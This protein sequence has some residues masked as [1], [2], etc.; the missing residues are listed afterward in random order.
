MCVYIYVCVL[1]IVC[2]LHVCVFVGIELTSM[3]WNGKP[4]PSCS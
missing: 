2:F 3:D 1:C 4:Y